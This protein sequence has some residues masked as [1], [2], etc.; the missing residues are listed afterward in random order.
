MLL[1]SYRVA[2]V[3]SYYIPPIFYNSSPDT[4]VAFG[5]GSGTW[6]KICVAPS[7]LVIIDHDEPVYSLN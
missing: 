6:H 3:S 2:L 5:L 1:Q 4:G 7:G